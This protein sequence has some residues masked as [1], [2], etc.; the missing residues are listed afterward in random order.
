MRGAD[1]ATLQ[2]VGWGGGD[3]GPLIEPR[4]YRAAF[5]PALVATILAMFSLE[6][7]PSALPQGLAAGVLFDGKNAAA[8]A[9]GARRRRSLRRQHRG[10]LGACD[11]HGGTRPP[12][13]DAWGRGHRGE[14]GRNP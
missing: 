2:I 6:A 14:G 4:L 10:R 7:R 9:R 8:P 1:S 11:R 5:V 12:A 3:S 13:R